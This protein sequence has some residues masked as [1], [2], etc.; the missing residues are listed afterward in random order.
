MRILSLS[1]KEE[2]GGCHEWRTEAPARYLRSLGHTVDTDTIDTITRY[3]AVILNRS[4]QNDLPRFVSRCHQL[5]I[6]VIYD[7]DDY[8]LGIE[9]NNWYWQKTNDMVRISIRYL[10]AEADLVTVSTNELQRLYSVHTNRPIKVVPNLIDLS[11]WSPQPIPK[12]K[13]P[14]VGWAGSMAHAADLIMPL[15]VVRDLQHELDFEF[16]LFGVTE[17]LMDT[18]DEQDKN[19]PWVKEW[20]A[21]RKT[22]HEIKNIRYI[23]SVTSYGDYKKIL[24]GE[25]FDI[26]LAPLLDTRFNRAKSAVKLYEY[27]AAGSPCMASAVLPYVGTGAHTVKNRYLVWKHALARFINHKEERVALYNHQLE[28]VRAYA[29]FES[30]GNIVEDI[31]SSII[32]EEVLA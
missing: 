20:L 23:P 31:Y 26:G 11:L 29:T 22:C 3:D 16:V 14:V 27:V 18:V 25:R 17:E 4:F 6:K 8:I 24:S 30:S 15:E 9:T 12:R 13:V 1:V 28:K 10:L 21:L 5:G 2:R 19:L 7:T 32:K